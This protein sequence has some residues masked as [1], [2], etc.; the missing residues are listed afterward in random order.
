M[1]LDGE[2]ARRETMQI[3]RTT[4]NVVYP[5]AGRALEVVVMRRLA[6]LVA[7]CLSRQRDYLHSSTSHEE[8]QIAI[9][10]GHAK[11]T[12][13]DTRCIQHLLWRQRP[14][15]RTDHRPDRVAL[16]GGAFYRFVN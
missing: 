3:P 7:R 2:S 1:M 14:P 12:Y 9:Y 8:L 6:N 10:G 4:M 13:S 16:A 11:P 15:G 5:T